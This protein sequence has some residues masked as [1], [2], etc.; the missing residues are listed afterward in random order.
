MISDAKR[1]LGYSVYTI[2]NY[3]EKSRLRAA[4]EK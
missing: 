3:G 1:S 2:K 4:F